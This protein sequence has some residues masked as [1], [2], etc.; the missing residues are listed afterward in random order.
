MS[1]A[2]HEGRGNAAE[3]EFLRTELATGLTLCKIAREASHE[4]K[5]ERN[6]LNARKAYDS[7][8]HFM[9]KADIV[10]EEWNDI[11]SR[12]EQL[13]SELRLLGEAV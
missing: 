7:I 12:L 10:S 13:R 1:D 11:R 5:R 2:S 8:L 9:P 4:D 3:I 6:R